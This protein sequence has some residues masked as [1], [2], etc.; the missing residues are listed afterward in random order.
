MP[1]ANARDRVVLGRWL[2]G[3]KNLYVR[4]SYAPTNVDLRDTILI[5]GE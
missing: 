5:L 3:K 2:R 4:E 1:L